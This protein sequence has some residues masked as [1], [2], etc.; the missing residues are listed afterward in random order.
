MFYIYTFSSV[1]VR[2]LFTLRKILRSSAILILGQWLI[3]ISKP[4]A[5]LITY[6]LIS[7]ELRPG[8]QTKSGIEP[9]HTPPDQRTFRSLFYY[10]NF[11]KLPSRL[12]AEESWVQKSANLDLW[13]S[14]PNL[15]SMCN[16]GQIISSI[17]HF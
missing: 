5:V 14:G 6:N 3:K 7:R 2:V 8:G 16:L 1:I 17:S 12:E 13:N 9:H 11:Q 4:Q 10:R 15:C